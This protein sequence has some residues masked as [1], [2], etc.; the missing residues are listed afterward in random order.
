MAE[1]LGAQGA[2]VG[3]A[4]TGAEPQVSCSRC[5]AHT[6]V[7]SPQPP[8][9]SHGGTATRGT[10]LLCQRVTP[11]IPSLPSIQ[12]VK[13]RLEPMEAD[14]RAYQR[15]KAEGRLDEYWAAPGREETYRNI[16]GAPRAA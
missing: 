10:A 5:T 16:V 9:C 3:N 15:A 14:R 2:F 4:S 6:D 13:D 8:F 1:A 7:S 12:A 11:G